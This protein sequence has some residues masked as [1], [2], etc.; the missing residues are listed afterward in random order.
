VCLDTAAVLWRVRTRLV[1]RFSKVGSIANL[2]SEFSSVL[3][4]ENYT[5]IYVYVYMYMYTYIHMYLCV[6]IYVCIYMYIYK[7]PASRHRCC[8]MECRGVICLKMTP[9]RFTI[10]WKLQQVEHVYIHICIHTLI[11]IHIYQC[12]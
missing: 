2:H 6:Y 12:I 11:Y 1:G 3:T 5:R 4:F 10:R 7:L 9:L 8:F